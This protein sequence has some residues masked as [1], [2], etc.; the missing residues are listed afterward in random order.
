[1]SPIM[2]RFA[3]MVP[4]EIQAA[5]AVSSLRN[6][7]TSDCVVEQRTVLDLV[8]LNTLGTPGDIIM[9]V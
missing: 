6:R 7:V 2:E 8:P 3:G 5:P 9:T 1:M 4:E